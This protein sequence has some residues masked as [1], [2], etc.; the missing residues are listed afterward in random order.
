MYYHIQYCKHYSILVNVFPSV[1][2]LV[3]F[4]RLDIF[5]EQNNNQCLLKNQM[6]PNFFVLHVSPYRRI[7]NV[8]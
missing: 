8:D 1:T 3:V 4:P 2:L 5:I 6:E 7:I